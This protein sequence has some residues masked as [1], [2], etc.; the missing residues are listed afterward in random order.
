[1]SRVLELNEIRN[2]WR[3]TPIPPV[4]PSVPTQTSP[5]S[6]TIEATEESDEQ[7][8]EQ[9]VEES[10]VESPEVPSLEIIC[11]SFDRKKILGIPVPNDQMSVNSV[12]KL[13][14]D[15]R[16]ILNKIIEFLDFYYF[17]DHFTSYNDL[18]SI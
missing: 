12:K 6:S 17:A 1:M 16:R 2:L 4:L 15:L 10:N 18:M 7:T 13:V 14:E 11:L 3:Q 5:T 8:V 9:F